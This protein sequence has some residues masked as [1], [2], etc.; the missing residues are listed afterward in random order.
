MTVQPPPVCDYEGSPYQRDF[1]D[2][3]ARAYEDLC[4]SNAIRR[5]LPAKGRLLLELGAGAGRNTARYAG[6]ERIVLLDYSRTQLQQ[7]R[8]RLGVSDR[9]IY[10]AGNVY[11]LPFVDGLFD[12]ATMIRTLHHMADP[13]AALN[14]TARVLE[15]DAAFLLE[16][17]NKRNLKA[18]LRYLLR[19]QEWNP[20]SPEPVE[21]TK[22]NFDF[23]PQAVRTWL[24][25][26]RMDIRRM[27]TVSHF[28][29]AMFKRLFPAPFL[30]AADGILGRTGDWIQLSPSVFI[31][32]HQ[33]DPG[34]QKGTGFFR[35][36]TCGNSDLMETA[37]G[38]K[39]GL[40]CG[41]CRVRYPLRDGIFDFKEPV[42]A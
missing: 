6:Y 36:P 40:R 41:V 13:Q 17:A 12:A 16:F 10:V 19:R 42:P 30:A 38:E 8:A 18:I 33:T 31:L 26:S 27:I 4:E 3:G 28:R 24:R 37:G 9:F 1:W 39:G 5:L 23:H 15:H 32:S 14:E 29:L 22:L 20:F 25:A 11:A 7:A 21:Y 34:K 2:S 35:C